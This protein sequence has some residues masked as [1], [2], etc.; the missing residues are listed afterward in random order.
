MPSPVICLRDATIPNNVF[1]ITDLFPNRSQRNAVI[2]PVAQGPRYLRQPET[3]TP[4]VDGFAIA[5]E[6]SGLIAYL[7]VNQDEDADV[8][9]VE[10]ATL[11]A[12]LYIT[13]MRNGLALDKATINPIINGNG[14]GQLDIVAE[15]EG[16]DSTATTAEI[17]SIL[18]GAKYTV[19]AGY[20]FDGDGSLN[21]PTVSFFDQS[22]FSPIDPSDSSFYISLARGQLSV[23]KSPSTDAKGNVIDP[24]VVVYRADGT[25]L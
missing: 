19:P 8:L 6:V 24:Q 2:D 1:Q 7:L 14:Q 13:R 17:L 23:A 15:I 12:N 21:N 18:S 25:L 4:V 16:A 5:K 22:V 20:V 10:N 9:S 3:E 11:I